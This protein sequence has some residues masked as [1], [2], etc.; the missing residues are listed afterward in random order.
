MG[1]DL[2]EKGFQK[3]TNYQHI[4]NHQKIINILH[5][6][7]FVFSLFFNFKSITS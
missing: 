1:V 4:N 5:L 3:M 2:V 7:V 6:F